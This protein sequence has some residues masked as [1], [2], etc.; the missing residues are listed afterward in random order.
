MVS[1]GR[2][3]DVLWQANDIQTIRVARTREEDRSSSGRLVLKV[4]ERQEGADVAVDEDAE[5]GGQGG[6]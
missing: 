5:I 6:T 4:I 1:I 3:G 2:A